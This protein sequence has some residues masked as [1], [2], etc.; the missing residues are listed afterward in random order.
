M[1]NDEKYYDIY[2]TDTTQLRPA[3]K[4]EKGE[5]IYNQLWQYPYVQLSA[6]ITRCS[7]IY[8]IQ[9]CLD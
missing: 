8:F 2:K 4:F 3:G 6:A 5:N 7:I 9:H 1:C